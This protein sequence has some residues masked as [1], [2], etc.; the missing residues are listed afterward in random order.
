MT[1]SREAQ[2]RLKNSTGSKVGLVSLKSARAQA[3]ATRLIRQRPFK[4]IAHYVTIVTCV[5]PQ[6]FF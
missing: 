6:K 3:P 2:P 1:A 4:G 5:A